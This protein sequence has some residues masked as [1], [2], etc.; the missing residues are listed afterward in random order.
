M[1]TGKT[2]E[3]GFDAEFGEFKDVVLNAEWL[4]PSPELQPGLQEVHVHA[5][6]TDD[7]DAESFLSAVYRNQR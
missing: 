5:A 7:V 1:T 3:D 2:L 6:G 4:P